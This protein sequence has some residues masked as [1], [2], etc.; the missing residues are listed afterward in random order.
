[1]MLLWLEKFD[2][3]RNVFDKYES[4]TKFNFYLRFDRQF[5]SVILGLLRWADQATQPEGLRKRPLL[6]NF[7]LWRQRNTNK[8]EQTER[9]KGVRLFN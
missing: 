4:I 3:F 9:Q 6:L 8:R 2:G 1:M 7:E 5:Q